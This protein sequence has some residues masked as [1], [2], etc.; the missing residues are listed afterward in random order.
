MEKGPSIFSLI[1]RVS[2][3][4]KEFLYP[5]VSKLSLSKIK[6]KNHIYVIALYSDLAY[7]IWGEFPNSQ[8]LDFF[9]QNDQSGFENLLKIYSITIYLLHY[10][11]FKNKP[12]LKE[13]VKSL[14]KE[15]LF[16]YKDIVQ[17][18]K[19]ILDSEKREELCRFVLYHLGYIPEQENERYAIERLS[20]LDSIERVKLINE[21]RKA[22]IVREEAIREAIRKKEAEEAASR[23][24]GE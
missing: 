20:S 11:Y 16:P 12:F 5:V 19:F 17:A 8:D 9:Y 2:E 15:K 24:S 14:F 10:S 18:E 13:K 7:F 4:P 22:Q 1:N 21:T 3:T 6:L 23:M